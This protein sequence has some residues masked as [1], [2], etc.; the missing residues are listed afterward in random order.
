MGG[1]P[2]DDP[3]VEVALAGLLVGMPPNGGELAGAGLGPGGG[4]VVATNGAY[5]A[6]GNG[7]FG[8]VGGEDQGYQQ[9]P[10][11]TY[12]TAFLFPLTGGSGGSGGY[13][14]SSYSGG[15]GGGGA[16]LITVSGTL[17]LNGTI[18]A[19]GGGDYNQWNGQGGG[20]G[21]AIRLVAQRLSG[22][23]SLSVSGGWTRL[24]TGAQARGSIAGNGRIRFDA[25]ENAFGGTVNG[26]FTQGAQFIVLPSQGQG[27]QLTVTAVGGIPVSPSPTGQLFTPDA[28]LAAQ[29][30]NPVPI[31]VR[32]SN[33]PLN[34]PVTV[35]V[36]PANGSTVS[37]VGYNNTGTVSNST[38]TVLINM[39]RGG[40]LIYATAATAN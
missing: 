39:P 18:T 21:G 1:I 5:I 28:I 26:V 10:G 15:G 12:G 29:Q 9:P 13:S 27:T 11:D 19:N 34:T 37:A 3:E 20:S 32:C 22:Q 23:G 16:I 25:V 7:S 17:Q 2:L 40:G 31:V 14:Y 33:L 6:G 4:R 35:S 30:A 36:K 8:G 24:F 38:A